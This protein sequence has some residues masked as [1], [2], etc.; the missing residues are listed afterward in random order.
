MVVAVPAHPAPARPPDAAARRHTSRGIPCPAW[1]LNSVAGPRCPDRPE[2][3]LPFRAPRTMF[4]VPIGGARRCAAQSWPLERV[5]NVKNAAGVS[6]N[7][8]VLAM[9]AGALR[10][11]LS[12]TASCPQH[13]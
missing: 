12:I 7:D 9:C 2:L 8:V 6:V 4:N 10:A 13:R 11:Y 1:S 5:K 3:T